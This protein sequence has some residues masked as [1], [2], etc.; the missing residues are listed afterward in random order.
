[1]T[2]RTMYDA[3]D[4]N[5]VPVDAQIV[6]YYPHDSRTTGSV[7]RFSKNTVR[8]TIDNH[9]DHPDCEVLD[10]EPGA[11]WPPDAIVDKWLAAKEA[12][13]KTGTIYSN[14]ANIGA[15]RTATKRAFDWWAAAWTNAPHSVSGSV[16][17]QYKNTPGYDLSLVTD[18]NWPTPSPK[19][20]P[21]R[22]P[23]AE[24][25]LKLGSTGTVVDLLQTL[26]NKRPIHPRLIVDG[27]FGAKTEAAVKLVQHNNHLVED[28]IV[29]PKTWA[30]LGDYS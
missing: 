21:E 17:T 6:A 16:A 28:G 11:A 27:D 29:G 26:L 18:A 25:Q 23:V 24:P 30:I 19:P 3:L 1:M 4:L 2:D 13:G 12:Q 15:V 20:K 5:A 8:V 14:E 22:H 9:G 7:D 10:V